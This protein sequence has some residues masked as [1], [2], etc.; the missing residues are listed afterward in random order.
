[1]DINE[2]ETRKRWIDTKLIKSGWTK[3]ID[4]SEVHNINTLHRTAVRELPT[5]DGF[6]DYMLYLNGKPY[7]VVEAKKQGLNPQNALQQAQRYARTV[8]EG[9]GEYNGYKIPFAYSTNG[10]LIWFQ[11][12]RTEQ[13]RSRPVDE[14]TVPMFLDSMLR[15]KNYGSHTQTAAPAR[16]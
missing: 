10:E 14:Y 8:R 7:A 3:I 4:F 1:M 11:D 12:F 13:S 9:L 5:D 15:S 16:L 2:A 6:A